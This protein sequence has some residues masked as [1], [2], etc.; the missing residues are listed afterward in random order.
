MEDIIGL[1][2][3]N[4]Q[5]LTHINCHSP[6]TGINGIKEITQIHV[7]LKWMTSLSLIN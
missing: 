1:W 4:S 5:Q 7:C 2:A 6:E 3:V